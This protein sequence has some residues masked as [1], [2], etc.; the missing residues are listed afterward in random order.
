M[1]ILHCI[2]KA[3]RD[4][5]EFFIVCFSLKDVEH[6]WALPVNCQETPSHCDNRKSR[7]NVQNAPAR[8]RLQIPL[9]ITLWMKGDFRRAVYLGHVVYCF[10]C[11]HLQW[12]A[13]GIILFVACKGMMWSGPVKL[14][15][16]TSPGMLLLPPAHRAL[17]PKRLGENVPLVSIPGQTLFPS[18]LSSEHSGGHTWS[19][20]LVCIGCYTTTRPICA[21]HLAHAQYLWFAFHKWTSPLDWSKF[22]LLL[23]SPCLVFLTYQLLNQWDYVIF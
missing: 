16:R 18:L 10:L 15:I 17:F 11:G 22:P 8:T 9:K 23:I 21:P 12:M 3:T 6:P 4:T 2:L 20:F 5:G 7:I 19:C 13:L 1:N 14:L